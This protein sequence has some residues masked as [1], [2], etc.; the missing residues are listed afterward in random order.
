MITLTEKIISEIHRN[1]YGTALK[2]LSRPWREYAE[3]IGRG[4]QV[5]DMSASFDLAVMEQVQGT[6]V[7]IAGT[8]VATQLPQKRGTR[9]INQW[10]ED[11]K[12]A[13]RG[14]NVKYVRGISEQ[15]RQTMVRVLQQAVDR[16]DNPKEIAKRFLNDGLQISIVRAE[17]I[18]V[19]EGTRAAAMGVMLAAN[20]F[21]Y[22]CTKRWV[23]S[24]DNRVRRSPYNHNFDVEDSREIGEP[25][26]N[27]EQIMFPGDPR[28]KAG[29]VVNCR[30]ML[31]LVAKRDAEGNLIPRRVRQ[32]NRS[33]LTGFVVGLTAAAIIE[34]VD[35][36]FSDE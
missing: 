1:A 26:F 5:G 4:E 6:G 3:V 2:E 33:L 21:P 23:S 9:V 15:Q 32:S 20:D 8:R 17:R 13:M 34:L 16:H 19:T 11:V 7:R 27:G 22:E 10:Q 29:N 28:C 24:R 36:L 12:W 35:Q 30:C 31:A 18:A 14:H 25:W